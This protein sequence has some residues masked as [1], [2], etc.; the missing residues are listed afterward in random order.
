[1][2]LSYDPDDPTLEIKKLVGQ[3]GYRL[4]VGDRRII[5]LRDDSIN[6]IAIEKIK[7]R[8]DVYK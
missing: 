6:V 1:M 5:F 8:G 2:K 3:S 4:R 7:S